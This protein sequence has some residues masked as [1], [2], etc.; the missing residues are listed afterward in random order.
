MRAPEHSL[1]VLSHV[2]TRIHVKAVAQGRHEQSAIDAFVLGC[3][4]LT[5]RLQTVRSADPTQAADGMS[6][7]Q[8]TVELASPLG[9]G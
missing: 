1:N 9:T 2:T 7:N 6:L 8:T 5:Q 4:E 3:S